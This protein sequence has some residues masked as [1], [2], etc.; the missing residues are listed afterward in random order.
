MLV[1]GGDV[2]GAS[3]VIDKGDVSSSGGEEGSR[4]RLRGSSEK[5]LHEPLTASSAT[6]SQQLHVRRLVSISQKISR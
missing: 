6:G 5:R 4:F 2:G 1:E 3:G